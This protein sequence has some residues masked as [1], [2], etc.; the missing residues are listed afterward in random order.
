M[1]ADHTVKEFAAFAR[2]I[3]LQAGALI[4]QRWEGPRFV[5]HK[6]AIDLVTDCDRAAEDLLITAITRAFPTHGILAEESGEHTAA[7]RE[8]CWIIDPLDGTTNWVHGCPHVAV[9]VALS[10][11]GTVCAGVVYDPLRDE[12]FHGTRGGGA[13]LRDQPLRPSATASLGDALLATG[14]PTDCRERAEFYLSFV[15][16][17][18]KRSRGLRRFGSAALDLCYVASGRFD[19]FWEW[20]LHAWD[21]AAGSLIVTEA[22][23]AVTNFDGSPHSPHGTQTLASNGRVHA[24]M[25]AVLTARLGG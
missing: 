18:M 5:E 6:S 22:G 3:A 23:G 24:A 16:A 4:R 15:A 14:F 20:N 2:D 7:G 17:M 1:E 13:W 21:T 25:V 11:G 12:L 10:H 8:Y 19:G 9:S